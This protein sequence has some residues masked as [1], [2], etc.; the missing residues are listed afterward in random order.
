MKIYNKGRRTFNPNTD[1]PIRP[2]FWT[3]VPDEQAEKLL[4]GYPSEL[5]TNSVA[6]TVVNP[7]L[8]AENK[9]LKAENEALS[10]RLV[11]MEK[12]L[13]GRRDG[14]A[15]ADLVGEGTTLPHLPVE[16]PRAAAQSA[17]PAVRAPRAPQ[18]V[19][20]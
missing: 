4:K 11:N 14:P 20:A 12:L 3:E 16:T 1:C 8:E 6:M 5:T 13:S 15:P 10:S 17:K 9:R 18:P 19:T 2:G 7:A